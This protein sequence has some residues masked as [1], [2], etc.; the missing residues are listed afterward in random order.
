[1][2]YFEENSQFYARIDLQMKAGNM[3]SIYAMRSWNSRHFIYLPATFGGKQKREIEEQILGCLADRLAYLTGDKVLIFYIG[4]P[5][6]CVELSTRTY[7]ILKRNRYRTIY[8]VC[9][10]TEEDI[11]GLLNMGDKNREEIRELQKRFGD[12]LNMQ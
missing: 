2:H 9:K 7:N 11:T 5:L 12:D 1:V 6:E 3:N 8:D 4:T 10:M